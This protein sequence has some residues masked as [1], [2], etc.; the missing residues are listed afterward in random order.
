MSSPSE[1]ARA[2]DAD[3]TAPGRSRRAPRS[4]RHRRR[5]QVVLA[6]V[7]IA[8]LVGGVVVAYLLGRQPPAAASPLPLT[9]VARV[10]LPGTSTRFDYADIYAP[11]HALF[12]AQLGSSRLLEIDTTTRR[13]LRVTDGLADIHGVLVVPALHRVFATATGRTSSSRSTRRSAARCT[14]HR[15]ATTPTDLS[16]R[17]A[18]GR[19]GSATKPVAAKR[20]SMP[21]RAKLSTP[22]H[23]AGRWQRHLRP[24]RRPHPGRRADPQRDRRHRPPQPPHH[25]AG[26]RARLRPRPQSDPRPGR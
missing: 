13:V 26:P 11:A 23:W 21:A 5:N 7:I 8:A 17:R 18:T 10:V 12:L 6:S 4:A 9:V 20:L 3:T 16:T 2:G 15:P 19:S 24:R 14:G 25:P 1:R 22:S